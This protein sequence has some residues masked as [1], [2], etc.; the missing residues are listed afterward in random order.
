[1]ARRSQVPGSRPEKPEK[2]W[3]PEQPRDRSPESA[4]PAERSEDFGGRRDIETADEPA[5]AHD[6]RHHDAGRAGRD[7]ESSQPG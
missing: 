7:V 6:R 5:E 2:V 4:R 1:M 3:K